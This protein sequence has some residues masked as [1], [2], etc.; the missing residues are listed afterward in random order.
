MMLPAVD[1]DA[2][3]SFLDAA[4]VDPK[5][6]TPDF[7]RDHCQGSLDGVK[8]ELGAWSSEGYGSR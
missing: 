7:Y 8:R 6:S 4:N 1:D 3:A 2:A 5:A